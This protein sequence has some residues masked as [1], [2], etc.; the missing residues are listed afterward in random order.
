MISFP[1]SCARPH[2]IENGSSFAEI[3]KPVYSLLSKSFVH[4]S[5]VF[6][7]TIKIYVLHK[8]LMVSLCK[9]TV[10]IYIICSSNGLKMIKLDKQLIMLNYEV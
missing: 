5:A 1:I 6:A 10:S 9:I 7:Y 2:E 8:L 4:V 3:A